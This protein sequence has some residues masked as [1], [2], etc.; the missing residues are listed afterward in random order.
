MKNFI[1]SLL[2]LFVS[3]F[4]SKYVNLKNQKFLDYLDEQSNF[5]EGI[6]EFKVLKIRANYVLLEQKDTLRVVVS[7][8]HVDNVDNFDVIEGSKVIAFVKMAKIN[9][10]DKN[11]FFLSNRII[12]RV[13]S[14]DIV[15]VD[16]AGFLQSIRLYIM[17]IMDNLGDSSK[18][19]KGVVFGFED[20]SFYERKQ[21]IEAGVYHFFVASGSNILLCMN[22]FFYF[23]YFLLR[24]LGFLNP[25]LFS[26]ICSLLLTFLY[27]LV[28]GFD[29][30]LLRAFI[31]A[32]FANFFIIYD[33][34]NRLFYSVVS[35]C[36]IWLFFLVIDF[37]STIGLSFKL[38]FLS[39]LGVLFIGGIV[40]D[41]LNKFPAFLVDNVAVNFSVMVF[42]FPIFLKHFGIFYL[43]GIFSNLVIAFFVPFI[44]FCTFL[45]ILFIPLGF[46]LKIFFDY[47]LLVV[48]FV[49]S[50]KPFYVEFY[51]AEIWIV[52]YYIFWAVA[53]NWIELLKLK[54]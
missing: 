8:S 34:K 18:F 4:I 44:F 48:N 20:Y 9:D 25:K 12:Y 22:F 31:F 26:F 32:V 21:L 42:I 19:V 37:Y 24:V 7:R 17:G 41:F 53:G 54:K 46:I 11:S 28:V 36:F 49:I 39:F 5:I 13:Y 51:P 1:L 27:C 10:V 45:Y 30:P 29:T 38:S 14:M 23:F 6:F 50:V 47:F 35:V 43:N 3:F 52:L 2:F 40:K 15:E 33:L 16:N